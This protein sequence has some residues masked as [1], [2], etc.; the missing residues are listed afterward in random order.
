MHFEWD[1]AKCRANITKHGFDFLDAL[2]MFGGP[3]QATKASTVRGEQ[4]WYATGI[5]NGLYATVVFTRRAKA[6]RLI[7]LRRA[8]R[9]EREKHRQIFGG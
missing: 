6:I 1:E 4:R 2:T 3:Y 7:S 5:L 8:R 9:G